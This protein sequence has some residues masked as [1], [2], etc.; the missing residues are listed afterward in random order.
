MLASQIFSSIRCPQVVMHFLSEKPLGCLRTAR[1]EGKVSFAA[2]GL[3]PSGQAGVPEVWNGPRS[4]RLAPCPKALSSGFG[5]RKP[6]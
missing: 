5:F 3:A 6:L 4:P 2:A 1:E